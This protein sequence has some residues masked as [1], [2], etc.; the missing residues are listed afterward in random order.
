MVLRGQLEEGEDPREDTPRRGG[1]PS[2]GY[3]SFSGNRR[4]QGGDFQWLRLHFHCRGHRVHP[5]L[6]NQHPTC[7]TSQV[8]MWYEGGS[9]RC[10][11]NASVQVTCTSQV[12]WEQAKLGCP[13]PPVFSML[14]NRYRKILMHFVKINIANVIMNGNQHWRP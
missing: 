12:N 9:S 13:H 2:L 8:K 3:G 14:P 11:S 6:G 5:W 1:I 10:S 7:H 4:Q